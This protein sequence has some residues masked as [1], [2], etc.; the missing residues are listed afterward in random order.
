MTQAGREGA[1][2]LESWISTIHSTILSKDTPLSP[3]CPAR[4]QIKSPSKSL[5]IPYSRFPEA[6]NGRS[7]H[8]KHGPGWGEIEL[9]Q[10]GIHGRARAWSSWSLACTHTVV[11]SGGNRDWGGSTW[12]VGLGD[13]ERG[14]HWWVGR[15][16]C[17][18]IC[19]QRWLD[20]QV[21]LEKKSNFGFS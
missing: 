5:S 9:A 2:T 18:A 7:Q 12:H 14:G 8:G 21:G 17:G 11:Q 19:Q 16:S 6:A 1:T 4:S 13:G 15:A 10:K 3:S 20:L